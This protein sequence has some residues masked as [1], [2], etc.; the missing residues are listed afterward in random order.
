MQFN[1]EEQR[2]LWKY[3]KNLIYSK[4][5]WGTKVQREYSQLSSKYLS[6]CIYFIKYFWACCPPQQSGCDDFT[7]SEV[8]NIIIFTLQQV[9]ESYG[10]ISATKQI[11]ALNETQAVHTQL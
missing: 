6:I 9:Q 10:L 5:H 3:S 2:G 8:G 4:L 7:Q 1:W 11:S